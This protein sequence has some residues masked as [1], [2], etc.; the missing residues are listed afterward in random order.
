MSDFQDLEPYLLLLA[1]ARPARK[2]RRVATDKGCH[3]ALAHPDKYQLTLS[4]S[5][6][7]KA[8]ELVNRQMR[9]LESNPVRLMHITDSDYPELLRSSSDPPAWLFCQGDTGLLKSNCI[10]VVGSRNATRLSEGLAQSTSLALS[11]L[12][13]CIVSGLARGVD[14][15]AHRGAIQGSGATVAV[16]G[17]GLDRV[18]PAGHFALAAKITESGACISEYPPLTRIQKHHFPERNRIIAG[19]SKGVVIIEAG[20][21]SGSLI[22]AKFALEEGREV[23]AVPGSIWDKRYEGCHLLLKNGAKLTQNL[24][25]ILEELPSLQAAQS[26]P[27]EHSP[28]TPEPELSDREKAVLKAVSHDIR[29]TEEIAARSQMDIASASAALT[30]LELEDLVIRQTSGYSLKPG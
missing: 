1:A 9:W 6:L 27:N 16:F 28:E 10:A 18:Y 5:D 14:A 3:K 7:A 2:V 13:A 21:K 8:A 17:C 4:S 30:M 20:A 23:F 24:Q 15:A 29:S 25:D 12:N 26:R 22:T 19:I 11:R